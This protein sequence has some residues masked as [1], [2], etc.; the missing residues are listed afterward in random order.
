MRSDMKKLLTKRPRLK[1]RT[2]KGFKPN[3]REFRI[4]SNIRDDFLPK[5][6]SMKRQHI[7]GFNGKVV[8]DYLTPLQRFLESRVNRPW[9]DVWS[10][11]CRTVGKSGILSHHLKQHVKMTVGGIPHSNTFFGSY[12]K[13]GEPTC[14]HKSHL[15]VDKNGILR[16]N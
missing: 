5:F 16:R 4:Y 14:S 8:N 13:T 1:G 7:H 6:E 3:G 9:K 11:I 15:Y 10:E 2:K 12:E